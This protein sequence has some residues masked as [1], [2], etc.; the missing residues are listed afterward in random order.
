MSDIKEAFREKVKS[1]IK[2]DA[3]DENRDLKEYGLNS[4]MV[5][6]ISAF[7]KKRG[8][9]VSFKELIED[10][11]LKKWEEFISK[12]IGQKEIKEIKETIGKSKAEALY[13]LT[14]VQYAY[15]AGRQN[16][17]ELGGVGCHAYF[18]FDGKKLDEKRLNEAFI[19]LQEAQP[20]LRAKFTSEGKQTVLDRTHHSDIV[21]KD[22][23]ALTAKEREE[24]L[25][26]I[27]KALS[28]EK[29]AVEEGKNL[30][31]EYVIL[32]E[33]NMRLFLDVDLLVADVASIHYLITQL[34]NLYQGKSIK[35]FD[36]AVFADYLMRQKESEQ[37]QKEDKEYWQKAAREYPSEA[38]NL[39]LKKQPIELSGV[40]FVRKSRKIN[41][42]K[43]DGIKNKAA[44]YGMSPAIYVK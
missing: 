17:Q 38:P 8:I 23:S 34:T 13:D 29:L 42:E 39:P 3:I 18:E 37:G 27:R 5:M 14:D 21:V 15:W 20:M 11:T 44:L 6:K 22:F 24:K 9:K 33:E 31:L 28:H 7:L 43:W 12:N 19:K 30:N 35:E 16:D 36:D 4:I 25:S 32:D 2:T 40:H 10:C 26:E 41:K 1:L